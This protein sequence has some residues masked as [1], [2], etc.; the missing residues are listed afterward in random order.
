MKP[1][2]KVPP[3]L[4]AKQLPVLYQRN[5]DFST[6]D[7]LYILRYAAL[8]KAIYGA[9]NIG[10]GAFLLWMIFY[11]VAF[12]P[13]KIFLALIALLIIGFGLLIC[14]SALR[15]ASKTYPA[16]IAFESGFYF[17]P[18]SLVTN[19]DRL[20]YVPWFGVTEIKLNVFLLPIG[21]PGIEDLV[22][23][24]AK[25]ICFYINPSVLQ[26]YESVM[27]QLP[28]ASDNSLTYLHA[29]IFK[30]PFYMHVDNLYAF[31]E[32]KII[33]RMESLRASRM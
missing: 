33:A 9:M 25:Y 6:Q 32:K 23:R 7:A 2:L 29:E 24:R 28:S 12:S 30:T 31:G 1:D 13:I 14:N 22:G 10:V 5:I 3:H 15:T 19:K 11:P 26:Y 20:V 16:F 8:P 21:S 4:Q 17:R 18:L 27:K